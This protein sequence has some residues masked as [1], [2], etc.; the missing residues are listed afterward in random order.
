MVEGDNADLPLSGTIR[1]VIDL[2]VDGG[3]DALDSR[4]ISLVAVSC[5]H[6][7][8][9]AISELPHFLLELSQKVSL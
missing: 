5:V 1:H 8:V 2:G 6:E 4:H 9:G 7:L 3:L